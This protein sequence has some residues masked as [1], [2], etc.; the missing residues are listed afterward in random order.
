MDASDEEQIGL[1]RP[2]Y[3][4]RD[5]DIVR[6]LHDSYV[7]EPKFDE[8]GFFVT[9]RVKNAPTCNELSIKPEDRPFAATRVTQSV[10]VEFTT[11]GNYNFFLSRLAAKPV[12]N[13]VG[14]K[15]DERCTTST[16]P[17]ERSDLI[18]ALI[19]MRSDQVFVKITW[20]SSFSIHLFS[21]TSD[22]IP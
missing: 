18:A 6:Y 4:W 15:S 19:G 17:I 1:R 13:A 20:P 12:M 16:S 10:I 2:F 9:G 21:G 11:R 22:G 7:A 5:L 8:L 3:E 14:K